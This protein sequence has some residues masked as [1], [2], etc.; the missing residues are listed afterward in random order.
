MK[1]KSLGVI[2]LVL[3]PSFAVAQNSGS[4][5]SNPGEPR[6]TATGVD[7]S[8]KGSTKGNSSSANGS[9]ANGAATPTE[10]NSDANAS[11]APASSGPKANKQQP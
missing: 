9:D 11:E 5:E 2:L 1:A 10:T 4:G 8:P 3:L 6:S 7:T